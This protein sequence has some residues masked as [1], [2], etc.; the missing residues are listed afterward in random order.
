MLN[1]YNTWT[2]LGQGHIQEIFGRVWSRPMGKWSIWA[3]WPVFKSSDSISHVIS[4]YNCSKFVIGIHQWIWNFFNLIKLQYLSIV[5]TPVQNHI[6]LQIILFIRMCIKAVSSDG[7]VLEFLCSLELALS[8]R[9]SS[10]SFLSLENNSERLQISNECV[11]TERERRWAV[12]DGGW[13]LTWRAI[14]RFG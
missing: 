12:K 3:E 11:L 14:L 9:V 1:S 4:T 5:Y 2:I 8:T 10:L 6:G 13:S 7:P